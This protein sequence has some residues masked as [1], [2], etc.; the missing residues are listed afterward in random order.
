MR[1][2]RRANPSD[3]PRLHPYEGSAHDSQASYYDFKAHPELIPRVLETFIPWKEY[4]AVQD[5]YRFLESVN[6]PHS[7]LESNDCGIVTIQQSYR[8]AGELSQFGRVMILQ[9]QLI[10]NLSLRLNEFLQQRFAYHLSRIEPDFRMGEFEVMPAWA[11]FIDLPGPDREICIEEAEY[12]I[13]GHPPGA[14]HKLGEQIQ[15]NWRSFGANKEA[16]MK[17]LETVVTTLHHATRIVSEEL[18]AS[19][20]EL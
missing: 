6:G 8:R 14:G 4:K 15:I 7:P 3:V 19:L 2:I 1:A 16:V 18:I 5:F 9:R 13:A 17:N 12:Y 20:I 10:N 11:Y